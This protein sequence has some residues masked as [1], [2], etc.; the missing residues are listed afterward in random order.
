M[1]DLAPLEGAGLPAALPVIAQKQRPTPVP[2]RATARCRVATVP[3][4]R[5]CGTPVKARAGARYCLARRQE[6][7]QIV[8]D[9]PGLPIIRTYSVVKST[10]IFLTPPE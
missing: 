4:A 3:G 7:Q 10:L 8:A 6:T 5:R 2:N 9:A 1:A